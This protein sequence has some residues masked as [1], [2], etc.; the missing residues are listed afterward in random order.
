MNNPQTNIVVR[1]FRVPSTPITK[2]MKTGEPPTELL[3][4]YSRS[5]GRF[6]PQPLIQ[7]IT[8]HSEILKNYPV[9]FKI[10]DW[11]RPHIRGGK[12]EVLVERGD[13]FAS[14]T[15]TCSMSDAF[16]YKTGKELALERAL[17]KLN[18]QDE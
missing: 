18:A 15:A 7:F 11:L 6:A 4:T 5:L 10:G 3:V 16:S 9:Y 13:R 8:K 1:H 14:G 12:T 2:L 17:A